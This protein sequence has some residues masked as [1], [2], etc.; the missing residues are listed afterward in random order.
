MIMSSSDRNP[1]LTDRMKS[2]PI[3]NLGEMFIIEEDSLTDA[4]RP[5]AI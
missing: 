2:A 3:N 1:K 5:S 4:T